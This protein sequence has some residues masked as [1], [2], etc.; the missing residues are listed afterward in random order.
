MSHT[1]TPDS[2]QST[3][4]LN[5]LNESS[6]NEDSI[7][8]ELLEN[9]DDPDSET[10]PA[11]PTKQPLQCKLS[12]RDQAA[13]EFELIKGLATSIAERQN[14][15]QKTA[16]THDESMSTF[17]RYVTE[18][19]ADLEPRMKNLAKHHINNVLFQAQMGTLSCQEGNSA[20]L[21]SAP[22][23]QHNWFAPN[24]PMMNFSSP[25]SAPE[26]SKYIKY[27]PIEPRS[28]QLA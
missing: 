4:Q 20:A 18:S 2:D 8:D 25:K 13:Q 24:P 5:S 11:L 23:S 19:L 16:D 14:K 3:D 10:T 1:T 6:G 21:S 12:R 15:R 7:A 22:S 17:G 27:P 9:G 26:F 28:K